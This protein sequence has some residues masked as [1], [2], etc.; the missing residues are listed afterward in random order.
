MAV[1]EYHRARRIAG[2]MPSGLL[3]PVWQTS[4]HLSDRKLRPLR[5]NGNTM[6]LHSCDLISIS[7]GRFSAAIML[8]GGIHA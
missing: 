2:I 8:S 4:G 6:E 5:D 3:Q 7:P 1:R